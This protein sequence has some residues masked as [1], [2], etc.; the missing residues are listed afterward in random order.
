MEPMDRPRRVEALPAGGEGF[1]IG[2]PTVM[3]LGVLVGGISQHPRVVDGSVV[4][5][6]MMDLTVTVDHNVVDGAPAARFVEDLRRFMETAK[7]LS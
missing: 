6:E 2:Q 3:T 4:V 1:G 5:R 7:V